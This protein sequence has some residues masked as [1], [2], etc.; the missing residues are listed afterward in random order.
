VVLPGATLEPALGVAERVRATVEQAPFPAGQLV[1]AVTVSCGVA[2]LSPHHQDVMQLLKS[3]DE[4][5][6]QAKSSGRN[7]VCQASPEPPTSG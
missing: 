3:A 7:R 1:I 2:V 5:L 4:A 6:Y